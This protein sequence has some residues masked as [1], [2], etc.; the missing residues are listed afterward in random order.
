MRSLARLLAAP[1]ACFLVVGVLLAP[2]P[3]AARQLVA[4]NGVPPGSIVIKTAERSLYLALGNGRA[5][6]YPVAVG[7]TGKAWQ[8]ATRIVRKV[9]NPVWEPPPAVRRAQPSLPAL[10]PPGPRNPLGPRALV[11]GA[12]DYAIHGTNDPSSIGRAVSWGCIRMHNAD[13]V[14][15]YERVR[16]GAPVFVMP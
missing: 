3:S 5:L 13:I 15:L 1:F 16:V 8:G 10:V 2:G 14:D 4:L 6:R 11:L 9:V 7:R 12:D